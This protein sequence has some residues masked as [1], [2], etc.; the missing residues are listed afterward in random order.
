[1]T[2]VLATLVALA[3]VAVVIVR[4]F[5]GP[6]HRRAAATAGASLGA[7][8][9]A[10]FAVATM[11]PGGGDRDSLS[12]FALGLGAV[13]AVT[14]IAHAFRPLVEWAYGAIG[15][16]AAVPAMVEV[17]A[18]PPC[19]G[20]V[21]LG[22]RV[23]AVVALALAAAGAVA[24]VVLFARVGP[25]PV[26]AWFGAVEVLAFLQAP[27]GLPIAL[28]GAGPAV[29]A[30]ASAAVLGLL[31]AVRPNLVVTAATICIALANLG[32]DEAQLSCQA[33]PG[34]SGAVATALVLYL[35]AFLGLRALLR[36][37]VR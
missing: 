26:L 35:A 10:V 27:G 6:S 24:G 20:G 7:G 36:T 25:M 21:G 17:V 29:L 22:G 12:V 23:M 34:V 16:V 11:A 1:M 33:V 37:L 9:L 28:S 19:P 5:R 4:T 8:L 31:A 14:A 30:L 13:A 32:L 3:V 15:A 18:G 2:E